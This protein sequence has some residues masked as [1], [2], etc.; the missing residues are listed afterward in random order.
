MKSVQ[1]NI[2][3]NFLMALTVKVKTAAGKLLFVRGTLGRPRVDGCKQNHDGCNNHGISCL[4][5]SF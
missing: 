2:L 1:I 4:K 5:V 3:A